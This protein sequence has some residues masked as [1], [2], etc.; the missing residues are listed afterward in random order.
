MKCFNEVYL[1]QNKEMEKQ[2][3]LQYKIIQLELF[4]FF[5][6]LN[7]FLKTCTKTKKSGIGKL[8]RI[9]ASRIM[10]IFSYTKFL[11]E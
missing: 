10:A 11:L 8:A 7:F 1:Q 9:W 3:F 2:Y 5:S 6:A 4:A